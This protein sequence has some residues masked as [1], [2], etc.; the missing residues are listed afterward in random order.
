MCW[1]V[2]R[3]D[4]IAYQSTG[5]SF[6][7]YQFVSFGGIGWV[8]SVVCSLLQTLQL[9]R[10]LPKDG[11]AFDLFVVVLFSNPL[12]I[13]KVNY[14]CCEPHPYDAAI[15]FRSCIYVMTVHGEKIWHEMLAEMLPTDTWTQTK[16]RLTILNK[17]YM[18]VQPI[19]AWYA[20]LCAIS[21][22]RIRDTCIRKYH[23]WIDRYYARHDN[24]W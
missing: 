19:S 18:S 4:H 3:I 16:N 23:K 12:A 21:I 8:P 11:N 2:C 17:D 15:R 7:V 22:L 13:W 10:G 9:R 1:I 24:G 20:I 14:R 6:V 5:S